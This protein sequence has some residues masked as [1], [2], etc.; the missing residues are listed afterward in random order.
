MACGND[1]IYIGERIKYINLIYSL[2]F[3]GIIS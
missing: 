2:E 3:R 1:L